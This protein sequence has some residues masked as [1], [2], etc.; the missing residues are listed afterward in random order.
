MFGNPPNYVEPFFGSGAVLL[1]RPGWNKSVNWIE[2]VNDKDGFVCNFWRSV[3]FDPGKVAEYA[4]WPI[5]ESDL[6]ARHIWLR[7]RADWLVSQLEAEPS[8]Y[9]ARIAGYWVWG[10]SIWIG[11]GWCNGP[12]GA[13]PWTVI[14]DEHGTRLVNTGEEGITR[15]IMDM[16]SG[17]GINA[18]ISR[19]RIGLSNAGRGI[20]APTKRDELYSWMKLLQDRLRNV[21][22]ACGDWK[23]VCG[24]TPT[25]SNGLTGVFLDPPYSQNERYAN[26]YSA[27][28]SGTDIPSDVRQWCITNGNDKRFRIALCGYENEHSELDSLGWTRWQWSAHGGY[29]SQAKSG[30]N[31]NKYR[32]T[33]WFSPHCESGQLKLV[34]GV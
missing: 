5:N 3:Q 4:D 12:D 14:E 32:E 9:D 21:R 31:R 11:S 2:T 25:V 29:S 27:E 6:H 10:I 22:V 13:G 15:Q 33:I 34:L 24:Y 20:H 26:L 18:K 28:A 17:K 7:Q 23:R 30:E 16:A 1:G 19:K 8:Y